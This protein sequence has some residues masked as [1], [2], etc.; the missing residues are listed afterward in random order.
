MLNR[1]K[2]I[3]RS[4]NFSYFIRYF[5]VFT[6]I[7]GL[8]TMIIFQLMRSTMYQSSD[9]NFKEFINDP[10]LI[11]NFAMARGISA[12]AEVILEQDTTASSTEASSQQDD[13][14]K[15]E[16][17]FK[18]SKLR[19]NTN[20]HVILYDKDGNIVNDLDTLSGLST[21][22]LDSE[23]LDE[24]VEQNVTT[25]FGDEENYRMVTVDIS[26]EETVAAMNMN[27]HYATILY[28]TTQIMDSLSRYEATVMLVMI[29]FWLISI[30]AS[31]YLARDSVRP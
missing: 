2:R 8:M 16:V 3:Y 14:N 4:E 7:F 27:I 25:A 1:I 24:I 18:P 26:S 10:S 6:L 19:L 13:T 17:P 5:T 15:P 12:D 29:S 11:I 9:E 31:I 22:K 21:I 28:N 23:N 20:Y 30:I